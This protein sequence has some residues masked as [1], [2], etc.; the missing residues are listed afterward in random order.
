M[1]GSFK[2]ILWRTAW[3]GAQVRPA[4]RKSPGNRKKNRA[5]T[6]G[7]AEGEVQAGCGWGVRLAQSGGVGG[8]NGHLWSK[9][10]APG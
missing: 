6:S 8:G 4:V 1:D 3:A 10:Q 7:K 2:A 9:R 5:P